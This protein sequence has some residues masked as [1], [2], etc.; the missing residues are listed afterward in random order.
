[1]HIIACLPGTPETKGF[2]S[3]QMIGQMQQHALF[4]N[5]G[6]GNLLEDEHVLIEALLQHKI[7]GAVLDVTAVEPIPPDS[8]LWSC[9]NTILSQ[10]SGGGKKNEYAG[11][12]DLFIQNLQ[13]F[14]NGLPLKNRIDFL[15]GY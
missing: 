9:A 7:G 10:H 2:F 8:K 15:K 14:K 3:N 1:M 13:N 11:I 6:R 4:C 12:V 5:V